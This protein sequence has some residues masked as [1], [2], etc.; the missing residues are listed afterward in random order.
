MSE[1]DTIIF[2][3]SF[4]ESISELDNETQ[5]DLYQAIF[6]FAFNGEETE[7]KGIPKAIFSLIKPLIS[8]NITNQKKGQKGG[9]PPKKEIDEDFVDDIAA[10]YQEIFG[11]TKM[12]SQKN[13]EKIFEISEEN[14][15]TSEDWKKIF[16]NAR[17]GWNYPGKHVDVSFKK[18]LEDWDSFHRGDNGLAPDPEEIALRQEEKER[19]KQAGKSLDVSLETEFFIYDEY[20]LAKNTDK[21]QAQKIYTEVY[22]KTENEEQALNEMLSYLKGIIAV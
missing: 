6:K 7:F 20:R 10:K 2:Y 21:L 4:Y 22:E 16:K 8:A 11:D 5:L 17:R 14:N 9:R 1:V 12:L 18:M 19:Q 15:L 13:R 3:R